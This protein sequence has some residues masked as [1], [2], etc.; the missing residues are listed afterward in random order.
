MISPLLLFF[1]KNISSCAKKES[2]ERILANGEIV[3]CYV[4]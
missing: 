3:F 4:I 2:L 1:A